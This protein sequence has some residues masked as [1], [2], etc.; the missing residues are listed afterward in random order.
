MITMLRRSAFLLLAIPLC[1]SQ[2][3]AQ[4]AAT[5]ETLEGKYFIGHRFG[6]SAL[7]LRADG[8]YSVESGDCTT[9]YLDSGTYVVSEGALRLTI[10]KY[11]AKRR[12]AD[13][14]INLLDPNERKEF[15]GG[16]D[17]GREISREFSLLPVAWSERTYLIPENDLDDFAGAINLGLEPRAELSA[18]PFYGSFY[19]REGDEQKKVAG[20]P[21]LPERWL[22][23]LLR[24]PV[25]A[26]I[27]SIEGDGPE[28]VATINK[29]S[30]A[31]LKVG[32]RLI[33]VDEEP[34]PWSVTEVSYVDGSTAKVRVGPDSKVG[35]KL[36]TKYERKEPYQ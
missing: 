25:T 5:P 27:V 18:E 24:K 32:V 11:V 8:T 28:K 34:T 13:R 3:V 9:E 14:E 20:P 19:L 10:L 1:A 29:G 6:A 33:G 23:L 15:Y 17:A 21:S 35:D 26:T 30:R 36:T 7:T 31:G 12:G 4:A 2:V 16:G 22:A